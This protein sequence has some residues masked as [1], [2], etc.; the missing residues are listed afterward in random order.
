MCTLFVQGRGRDCARGRSCFFFSFFFLPSFCFC[1]GPPILVSKSRPR[2]PKAGV[3]LALSA[4]LGAS[5][6]HSIAHLDWSILSSVNQRPSVSSRASGPIF[7]FSAAYHHMKKKKK[8][9]A[10]NHNLWAREREREMW[11]DCRV[12]VSKVFGAGA[13]RPW[14]WP[15]G[16]WRVRCRGFIV[17]NTRGRLALSCWSGCARLRLSLNLLLQCCGGEM[18]LDYIN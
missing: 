12:Y 10:C 18:G 5:R 16:C 3:N 6:D 4:G 13:E 17:C 7:C 11:S 9:C 2:G 1:E 14:G 8:T 15:G